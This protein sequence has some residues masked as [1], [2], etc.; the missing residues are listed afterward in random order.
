[1]LDRNRRRGCHPRRLATLG[2]L[3]SGLF[4]FALGTA[5]AS[6]PASATD[7]EASAAL[8][9]LAPAH[10]ALEALAPIV[11]GSPRA[12]ELTID[13]PESG[14]IFSG[15]PIASFRGSLSALGQTGRVDAIVVIDTSASTGRRAEPRDAVRARH[16]GRFAPRTAPASILEQ[17]IR[18][19]ERMLADVD[20][21]KTRL[22]IVTFA[23]DDPRSPEPAS[24]I[25]VEVPL[26]ARLETLDAG[27]QRVAAR[28]AAGQTDMAGALDRAV[29]ELLGRGSSEPSEGAS[30]VVVFLTDGTPT[31]PHAD[32]REN[33][34]EVFAAAE[35]AA[36][37]G[38]RVFSFAIGPE[39]I[40]RPIAAAE[41]ARRT[42][43]AFTPVRKPAELTQAVTR[44]VE[45]AGVG[46]RLEIRNT[47][48]RE[49]AQDLEIAEGEFSG[50][51][52]LRTGKNE[53][54]VR[55][56]AGRRS[57]ELRR[58]VHYAPGEVKVFRPSTWFGGPVPNP[59]TKAELDV[60]LGQRRELDFQV[61]EPTTLRGEPAK[62]RR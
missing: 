23:G 22:G 20:P 50:R 13:S 29:A 44:R 15:E 25:R 32:T 12:V 34:R 43:G 16:R 30:K 39:A 14:E 56:R 61:G 38:I 45:F 57:V 42:G 17:E 33:E 51:I 36:A 27:L 55:A 47:T 19:V 48:N 62:L 35:R 58:A 60:T 49:A 1:M 28:G 41:M 7:L 24:P 6:E 21:G 9:E 4:A 54:F 40:G 26:T 59:P 8:V 11:D 31:L 2:A 37:A 3:G 53:I 46:G 10:A 52:A 18:S 5:T